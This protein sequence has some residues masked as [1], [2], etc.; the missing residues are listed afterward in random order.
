MICLF[1]KKSQEELFIISAAY[2]TEPWFYQTSQVE[3]LN[4]A[5]C[6][7]LFLNLCGKFDLWVLTYYWITSSVF[8]MY[9][10][11]D[12][13]VF[14]DWRIKNLLNLGLNSK[15]N[16]WQSTNIV[17]KAQPM[18]N[19]GE[20]SKNMCIS[21]NQYKVII[22]F[23]SFGSRRGIRLKCQR[24]CNYSANHQTIQQRVYKILL[25]VLRNGL[26]FIRSIS[27]NKGDVLVLCFDSSTFEVNF[28]ILKLVERIYLLLNCPSFTT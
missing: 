26:D 27:K 23:V 2:F 18:M 25:H 1:K 3:T 10:Q 7:C 22:I 19:I 17:N 13:F 9:E 15:H 6:V 11:Q 5:R 20:N 21:A 28:I 24:H 4:V 8:S 12:I 16:W 14:L